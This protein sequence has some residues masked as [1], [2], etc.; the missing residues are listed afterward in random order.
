MP[1]AARAGAAGAGV[2]AEVA[3]WA[4]ASRSRS[5]RRCRKTEVD[6]SVTGFAERRT[7]DSNDSGSV[8]PVAAGA[9]VGARITGAAGANGSGAGAGCVARPG[10]ARSMTTSMCSA[11]IAVIS[12]PASTLRLARTIASS[13]SSRRTADIASRAVEATNRLRLTGHLR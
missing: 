2:P 5:A 9:A 3:A 12:T 11:A 8:R 7:K 13:P 10:L 4:A 6:D 1:V